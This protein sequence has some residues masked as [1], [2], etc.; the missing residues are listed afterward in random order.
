[1]R[2]LRHSNPAVEM[3]DDAPQSLSRQRVWAFRLLAFGFPSVIGGIVLLAFMVRHHFIT[4]DDEGKVVLQRP[5]YLQEPGFER[6]G[7]Q[8]LYDKNLG[9]KNIPNFSA[10][11]FGKPLNISRQG[12]RDRYYSV[13][14][15]DRTK[16]VL[17]LGDSFTWGYGVADDEIF[18]EVLETQLSN[19]QPGGY[20]W[21]VIN[22]GVSGWGNDQQYL[23]LKSRGMRFEPD[24]VVMAF[25]LM[26][27]PVENTSS[28]VYEMNKPIFLDTGLTVG[29]VPVPPP[30]QRQRITT[31]VEPITMTLAIMQAT[32]E[33]CDQH[34]AEL[35]VMKFGQFLRPDN[36]MLLEDG[37]RIKSAVSRWPNVRYLDLDERFDARGLSA[38]ELTEGNHDEHWNA[39]GHAVVAEILAEALSQKEDSRETI[40]QQTPSKSP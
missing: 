38:L 21:E 2:P 32:A 7:H 27:D 10:T 36:L 31:S 33:F 6:S 35:M 22:T 40:G 14:K 39:R 25:F 17:V 34:D 23:F 13:E 29:N 9:W 24:M 3:N 12:L 37:D 16:R 30:S 19:E 18:T 28:R 5:I 8:Y 26:N 1:M 4:K 20:A 15:P 11:T